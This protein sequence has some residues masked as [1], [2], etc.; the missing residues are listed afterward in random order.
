MDGL[1]GLAVAGVLALH[2]STRLFFWGWAC[3]DLFFVLSGYLITTILLAN[4][5]S[6]R[7]LVS[8]YVRRALRIWPVYYL[9]LLV[10][11]LIYF[12]GGKLGSGAWPGMP[13]GQWLSFIFLQYTDQYL[14][15]A[16][17]IE[18][19]WYFAH[20]W[21]LAVEEQFYLL[22]PLVFFLLRPGLRALFA[23]CAVLIALAM[24]AR[25]QGWY[26]Y[27]L[28]TRIDGLLFGIVLAYLVSGPGRILYRLPARWLG[29]AAAAGVVLVAPYLLVGYGHRLSPNF[30]D[31][32][33]EVAA[34][35]LLSAALVAA[36]VRWSGAAW[37]GWLRVRP[38]VHLGRISFAVY[39]YH[40]P[41]GYLTLVAVEHGYLTRHQ[42][43]LAMW[44]VSLLVAHLSFVLIE[45]QVLSLKERFPY[46]RP[47]GSSPAPDTTPA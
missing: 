19:I 40:V 2:T 8:F 46:T 4:A 25:A 38:L 22:W 30:S 27:L 39:M 11:L 33:V 20:S 18:Y 34:F 3:V 7:M 17:D 24:W 45:R 23:G 10:T 32:T 43:H 16:P 6:P 12:V 15:G 47:A 35:C 26:I 42:G 13:D 9:A 31:R 36:A 44:I 37:L 1:R 5:G 41:V 29:Y 14:P 21:S 28:L